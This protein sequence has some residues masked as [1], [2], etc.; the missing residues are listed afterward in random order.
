MKKRV[1][2]LGAGVDQVELIKTL[3][4]YKCE[5]FAV[6]KNPNAPGSKVADYFFPIDT[7]DCEKLIELSI[8][9]NI[10]YVAVVSTERPLVAASIISQKLNL[11]FLLTHEQSLEVTDKIRMKKLMFS[12]NI[13]SAKYD[14]VRSYS[15][16]IKKVKSF[17]LPVIIKPTDS[18]GSRGISIYTGQEELQ[19]V[20]DRAIMSSQAGSCLVEEFLVNG[21]E[22]SIDAIIIQGKLKTIMTSQT[23]T[24][25]VNSNVGIVTASIVPAK[26]SNEMFLLAKEI[27]QSIVSSLKLTN[28]LFFA[29]FIIKNN[30]LFLLEYSARNTGGSKIDLIKYAY[31]ID[32][33]DLYV[34]L[35]FGKKLRFEEKLFDE[36]T[37]CALFIYSQTGIIKSL[38]QLDYLKESLVIDKFFIYK[39]EGSAIRKIQDRSDRVGVVF[40][41]STSGTSGLKHKIQEFV[42]EMKILDDNNKDLFYREI[43]QL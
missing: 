17:D 2:S 40:I 6:D 35:L 43:Y 15:D 9:F 38:K 11:P 5:V 39:N 3:Q 27:M 13:L 24:N 8:K 22:I 4:K 30:N 16:L 33:M 31:G 10:E 18:S 42:S 29:Q 20:W 14:I 37:S 21:V 36:K 32:V 1:L 12:N 19:S 7:L 25:T 34:S 23:I 41:S 26:I 28:S